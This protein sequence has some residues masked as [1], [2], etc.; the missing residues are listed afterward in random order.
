MNKIIFCQNFKFI[1][2]NSQPL[3]GKNF[4]ANHNSIKS[5]VS[6]IIFASLTK[7]SNKNLKD[8]NFKFFNIKD[9]NQRFKSRSTEKLPNDNKILLKR[10][11]NTGS[12]PVQ[13]TKTPTPST[14][15]TTEA[16][17]KSIFKRFKEA[18]KQHGQVLIY[19]HI[20]LCCGWIVSFYFLS[21]W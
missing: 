17:S 19:T 15:T 9:S 7:S 14:A 2:N 13:E 18:Y 5:N 3:I 10:V 6:N 4:I 12:N 16:Q 20:V 21:T 1:L 11:Y 8:S